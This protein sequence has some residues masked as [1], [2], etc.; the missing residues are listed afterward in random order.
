[1]TRES[2]ITLTRSSLRFIDVFL[3]NIIHRPLHDCR[4]QDIFITIDVFH[5]R[6]TTIYSEATNIQISCCA[7]SVGEWNISTKEGKRPYWF[8]MADISGLLAFDGIIDSD[9]RLVLKEYKNSNKIKLLETLICNNKNVWLNNCLLCVSMYS[10]QA[11]PRYL[12]IQK[13][14]CN[15]FAQRLYLHWDFCTK[16]SR[17]R[18]C[19]SFGKCQKEQWSL[20]GIIS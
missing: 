2:L 10:L 8:L 5:V 18:N 4:D 14:I 20:K 6:L 12:K 16:S 9:K 11:S 15:I 3:I 1:M 17:V 7:E 19:R 13:K